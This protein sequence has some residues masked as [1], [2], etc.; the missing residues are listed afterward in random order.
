[1]NRKAE[2]EKVVQSVLV[3]MRGG[4]GL[5]L[6][7]RDVC[8]ATIRAMLEFAAERPDEIVDTADDESDE[9]VNLWDR[10]TSHQGHAIRSKHEQ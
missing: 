6:T 9:K 5:E 7:S 2:V 3:V 10:Y 4:L 1:M 8:R